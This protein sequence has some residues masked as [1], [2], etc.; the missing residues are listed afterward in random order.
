MKTFKLVWIVLFDGKV[1]I[2]IS[3]NKST[4]RIFALTTAHLHAS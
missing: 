2:T 1:K 4:K 3:I